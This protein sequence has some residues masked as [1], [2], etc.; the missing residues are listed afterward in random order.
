MKSNSSSDSTTT[1]ES[2]FV[3]LEEILNRLNTGTISLDESL[4]LYEEAD[5]LIA[6]CNQQLVNAEKKI[7]V[8]IKNRNG[9]LALGSDEKPITQEYKSSSQ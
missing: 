6:F 3:R 4:K 2:A 5:G 9:E 7:E 8:L 1:F